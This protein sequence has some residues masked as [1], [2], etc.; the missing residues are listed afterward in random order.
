[1]R[2]RGQPLTG[3][4][5]GSR[6]APR[7]LARARGAFTDGFH[8]PQRE[9][10]LLR[11]AQQVA[12]HCQQQPQRQHQRHR[13]LAKLIRSTGAAPPAAR[14]RSRAIIALASTMAAISCAPKA[15]SLPNTPKALSLPN[16]PLSTVWLWS[17]SFLRSVRLSSRHCPGN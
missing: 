7:L 15:L 13:V 6:A 16:A 14:W 1:M 12:P 5:H 17:T 11:F 10:A 9:L 4:R 3:R 8:H 2:S